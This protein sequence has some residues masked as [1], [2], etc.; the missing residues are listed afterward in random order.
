[1]Y[2]LAYV[3]SACSPFAPA[4]L[5]ALL[6]KSRRNNAALGITG[7]LLY[8]DGN[9]MQ[10]L[11]GEEQPV[12]ALSAKIGRDPRHSGVVTLLQGQAPERE[13]SDW[14]MGFRDLSDPNAA[15][16]P[17]YSEFLNT[18]LT[19]DAFAGDPGRCR[20]L[21]SSFKKNMR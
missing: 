3:S 21:L 1:M 13:F 6:E 9:F 11:E 19:G 4:E 8:K 18:P 7:M 16:V 14:S 12:R 20:K 15:P 10:I 2:F 17:G 5:V